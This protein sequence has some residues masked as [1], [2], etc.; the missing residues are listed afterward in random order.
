VFINYRADD[1]GETAARL[2]DE[3]DRLL[4]PDQVFLDQGEIAP[5]RE[6]PDWL[7]REMARCTVML[8]LV[9]PLWL[10]VQNTRTGVRRLDEADDW[11]RRELEVALGGN[12]GTEVIPLLV[13]ATPH[14]PLEALQQ[15][16][17]TACIARFARLQTLQLRTGVRDWRSDR[18]VLVSYLCDTHRFRRRPTA[19]GEGESARLALRRLAELMFR[20]EVEH[21]V[22][23]Y[24]SVLEEMDGHIAAMGIY[25]AVH[26]LLYDVQ[27]VY[28]RILLDGANFPERERARALV[29]AHVRA[30]DAHVTAAA[31]IADRA[32]AQGV[33][34]QDR[35]RVV[36]GGLAEARDALRAAVTAQ[37]RSGY[38]GVVDALDLLLGTEPSNYNTDVKAVA[39]K[40]NLGTLVDL[41]RSIHEAAVAA[42][43][44]ADMVQQLRSGIDDL[45]AL[46]RELRARSGEHDALQRIDDL[47]RLLLGRRTM[48][49][50]LEA[51]FR[52]LAREV[53][54]AD[55]AEGAM[56]E[57]SP[58]RHT[59]P[60]QAV[61]R[62]ARDLAKLLTAGESREGSRFGAAL[63]DFRHTAA[64]RL[65]ATDTRLLSLC[66]R[67][68]KVR[69]PLRQL[70]EELK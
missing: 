28:D 52:T 16:G 11:V 59:G 17:T 33:E 22:R 12:S 23:P 5:G 62:L 37:D 20:T 31:A 48:V 35:V 8:S 39:D 43:V 70:L 30:L 1:T 26:D 67:I 9:G 69:P 55:A 18:D 60:E 50:G 56:R 19:P 45:E 21:A 42:K 13:N 6:W 63:R 61:S 66:D 32:A 65:W 3:L 54:H 68:Q 41:M 14:I 51:A 7:E 49:L 47:V 34:N 24:A 38:D 15:S 58:T 57:P 4:E 53:H 40:L 29:R 36:A 2:Y 46:A 25:K 27:K 10:S 64:D 44:A